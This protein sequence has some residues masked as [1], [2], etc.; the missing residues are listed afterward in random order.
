MSRTSKALRAIAA[1]AFGAALSAI[2][3]SAVAAVCCGDW[4]ATDKNINGWIGNDDPGII[5]DW[6]YHSATHD[7]VLTEWLEPS[8]DWV[9]TRDM[10]W[11]F[12][13]ATKLN[14][15]SDTRNL[16][17][18][19]KISD[20]TYYNGRDDN[21]FTNTPWSKAP[22]GSTFFEEAWDEYTEVEM[23]MIEPH[24]IDNGSVYFWDQQFDSEKSAVA[25][26]PTFSSQLENCN[27]FWGDCKYDET[28]W[29]RKKVLQQ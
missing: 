21:F 11:S 9:K 1:F 27:E 24:L 2:G 16:E 15:I 28:G 22:E 8:H 12:E 4:N 7:F 18:A 26:A 29:M 5:Q 19:V 25:G 17:F 23:E 14:E 20:E 13:A 3:V 6:A 10:D